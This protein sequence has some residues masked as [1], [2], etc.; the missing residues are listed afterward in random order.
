MPVKKTGTPPRTPNGG[1]SNSLRSTSAG[2]VINT[3][4]SIS[5]R[6]VDSIRPE[7][8]IKERKVDPDAID[9]RNDKPGEMTFGRRIALSLMK[10]SWYNPR[11]NA[12]IQP[13][14]EEK[15]AAKRQSK[16]L[17]GEEVKNV[18]A[19]DDEDDLGPDGER[20]VAEVPSIEKAWIYF[21]HVAL[22]RYIFRDKAKAKKALPI[23]MMRK[24]AKANKKFERAEPGERNLKTKLYSPIWTPHSQVRCTRRKLFTI[25]CLVLDGGT[26]EG[27]TG[28][29]GRPVLITLLSFSFIFPVRNPGLLLVQS[30]YCF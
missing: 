22:S 26:R 7:L 29:L 27:N 21:E 9:F 3:G 16:K 2:E 6:S 5:P 28:N 8:L 14:K 15:K 11:L 20:T 19:D 10:Q 4:K 12:P 30:D 23:R 18:A 17:K 24:F 25:L 13:T 1:T